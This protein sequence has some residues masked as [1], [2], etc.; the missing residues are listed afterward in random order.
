M[1]E[2]YEGVA[3]SVARK[4]QSVL[5][6][7]SGDLAELQLEPLRAAIEEAAL[8]EA[9]PLAA[10]PPMLGMGRRRSSLSATG[11]LAIVPRAVH[12]MV[13]GESARRSSLQPAAPL[14]NLA[15]RGSCP[16]LTSSPSANLGAGR[17][18]SV[19]PA[20]GGTSRRLSVAAVGPSSGPPR[21]ASVGSEQAVPS[22]YLAPAHAKLEQAKALLAVKTALAQPLDDLRKREVRRSTAASTPAALWPARLPH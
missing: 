17:R 3:L 12:G 9:A 10:A 20:G 15:R 16:S 21:R 7:E 22:K 8:A 5:V 14:A 11:S 19:A 2:M 6:A 4:L 18:L 1:S 13:P